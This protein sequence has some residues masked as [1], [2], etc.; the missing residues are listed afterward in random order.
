MILLIH[1]SGVDLVINA[2]APIFLIDLD[3]RTLAKLLPS[4]VHIA[5]RR[6]FRDARD[7]LGAEKGWSPW[8]RSCYL[9]GKSGACACSPLCCCTSFVQLI[10]II[11]VSFFI[12]AAQLHLSHV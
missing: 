7:A 1:S 5:I 8:G 9:R 10:P 6:E 12:Y 2:L 4:H 3:E 11:L